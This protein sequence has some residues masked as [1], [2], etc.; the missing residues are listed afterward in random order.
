MS[1]LP[2]YLC[3]EVF[4]LSVER[5]TSSSQHGNRFATLNSIVGFRVFLHIG[6]PLNYANLQDG[7]HAVVPRGDRK[8]SSTGSFPESAELKTQRRWAACGGALLSALS[9]LV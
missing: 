2:I 7:V 3:W 1:H 9:F 6:R 8:C 5:H 4:L